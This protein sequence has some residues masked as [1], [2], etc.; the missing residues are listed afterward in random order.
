MKRWIQLSAALSLGLLPMTVLAQ[1]SPAG[2]QEQRVMVVQA[3]DVQDD[4][5]DEDRDEND[6]QGWLEL[7]DRIRAQVRGPLSAQPDVFFFGEPKMEKAAFLGVRT[8]PVPPSL[9]PHVDLPPGVGLVVEAVEPDSPAAAA[10][11]KQY[12]ILHKLGDQLLI[13]TEQFAVLIRMNQPDAEITLAVVRQGKPLEVKA[14]LV[15]REVPARPFP[16]LDIMPLPPGGR[17]RIELRDW[18]DDVDDLPLPG[19]MDRAAQAQIVVSDNEHMLKI[20][21]RN[22]QRTLLATDKDGS[23]LYEG[24]IDTPEQLD[25]LPDG[26]RE[27]VKK[28]QVEMERRPRRRGPPTRPV[29]PEGGMN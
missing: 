26:I 14:R 19:R 23:V 18:F 2:A 29:P 17:G 1:A 8:A 27:K 7:A 16:R 6:F 21:V 3:Q 5:R 15:E 9:R 25:A 10:G 11:L 22:G 24:P 12:D 13:N 28:M 20:T 4:N